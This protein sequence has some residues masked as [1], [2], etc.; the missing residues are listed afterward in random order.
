[1]GPRMMIG[2]GPAMRSRK[3]YLFRETE[4]RPMKKITALL[5][6]GSLFLGTGF[7]VAASAAGPDLDGV[8]YWAE[9]EVDSLFSPELMRALALTPSQRGSFQEL[10]GRDWGYRPDDRYSGQLDALFGLGGMIRPGGPRVVIERDND[11]LRTFLALFAFGLLLSQAQDTDRYYDPGYGYDYGYGPGRWVRMDDFLY[12]FFR[13]LDMNQRYTF[14]IY[15]DRWYDDYYYRP[16]RFRDYHYRYYREA[17]RDWDRRLHLSEKQRRDMERYYDDLYN[18]RWDRERRYRDL[19]KDYLK[20]SWDRDSF[21]DIDRY[22]RDL[23]QRRQESLTPPRDSRDRF[24]SILDD[25]QRK[26]F[27][28]LIRERDRERPTPPKFQDRPAPPKFQEKPTPPKFQDRPTPPK[29]QEKPTPPKFQEKPTPPKFQEKPAPPKFQEKP[30]PPKFQEKPA[31]PKFQEKPA[32]PKF[33]EKPAPPKV[34]NKP[35]PP[36]FQEKPAPPKIPN[37]PVPPVLTKNPGPAPG[38]KK[39]LPPVVK[40]PVKDGK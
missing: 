35:A 11:N 24:R 16:D 7:S 26:T 39:P 15:F 23:L 18:R 6:L 38:Q 14:K 33:Q 25:G 37:K 12:L 17:M 28:S 3:E 40:K 9:E 19:E 2:N 36:K 31:P 29:F 13:I 27:D 20:R 8:V 4:V 22:R 5:V 21:G 1:M 34:P 10:R 32:P 30:A